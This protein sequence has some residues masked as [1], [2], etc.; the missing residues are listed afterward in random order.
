MVALPMGPVLLKG[1]R[2]SDG[3]RWTLRSRR[4]GPAR[5]SLPRMAGTS[6]PG[7][8]PRRRPGLDLGQPWSFV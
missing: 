7:P 3:Y 2:H 4:R 5:R 8:L 1:N 6:R